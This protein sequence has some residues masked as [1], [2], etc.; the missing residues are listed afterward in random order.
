MAMRTPS[1]LLI[2]ALGGEPATFLP[3]ARAYSLIARRRSS[4]RDRRTRTKFGPLS[5]F[6]PFHFTCLIALVLGTYASNALHGRGEILSGCIQVA[7]L[8]FAFIG[9]MCLFDYFDFLFSAEEYRILGAHPHHPWSVMLAK[10]M[11]IGRAIATQSASFS[12]AS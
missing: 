1:D 7:T 9:S 2:V 12:Q 3:V 8:G 10:S 6:A 11:V 5:W 4:L